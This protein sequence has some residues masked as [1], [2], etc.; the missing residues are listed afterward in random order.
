MAL[1]LPIGRLKTALGWNP[2]RDANPVP[3]SPIADDI[4]TVPSGPVSGI[5][6]VC[7]GGGGG[8]TIGMPI[9]SEG[10]GT[11]RNV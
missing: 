3:T 8:R 9:S 11:K 6:C 1:H 4:A 5:T 2:Y 10:V 7:V